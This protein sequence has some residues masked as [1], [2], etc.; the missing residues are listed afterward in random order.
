MTTLLEFYAEEAARAQL[1]IQGKIEFY[2]PAADLTISLQLPS[3]PKA[4]LVSISPQS[5]YAS[6]AEQGVSTEDAEELFRLFKAKHTMASSANWIFPIMREALADALTKTK[7]AMHR[8]LA[9]EFADKIGFLAI[10][11]NAS[12]CSDSLQ[13]I[14]AVVTSYIQE[15][16]FVES[17]GTSPLL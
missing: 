6:L 17:G 5:S 12:R 3:W 14:S 2:P 1:A 7:E 10:F 16:A 11:C 8:K 9:V 15:I 4:Q 13:K